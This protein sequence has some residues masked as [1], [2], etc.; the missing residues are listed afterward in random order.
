MKKRLQNI[1]DL[2]ELLEG[3][4]KR[5]IKEDNSYDEHVVR[6]IIHLIG[7]LTRRA[8]AVREAIAEADKAQQ[9]ARAQAEAEEKA[10]AEAEQ[11]A[12]AAPKGKKD[13]KAKNADGDAGAEGSPDDGAPPAEQ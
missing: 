3:Q 6:E 13:P 11:K 9:R 10:K 5:F 8:G 2:I 7:T 4:K 12:K 1:L